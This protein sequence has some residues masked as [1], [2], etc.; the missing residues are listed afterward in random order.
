MKTN[1]RFIQ[2]E[3]LFFHITGFWAENWVIQTAGIIF[4][5]EIKPL[6]L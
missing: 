3:R 6:Y 2:D 1:G 4:V 5:S